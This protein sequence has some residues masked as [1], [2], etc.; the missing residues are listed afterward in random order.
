MLDEIHVFGSYARGALDPHD[1]D[2]A[3]E[4]TADE[5][6]SATLAWHLIHGSDPFAAVRHTL[7]GRRRG[8][9]FRFHELEE[10]H[11][12]GIE[13]TLLWRRGDDLATALAR[14]NAITPDPTAGRAPRDGMLPAFEG[15][16][17]WVPRPVREMLAA[18]NATGAVKVE[19]IMLPDAA[20]TGTM[21]IYT[22]TRRW[23][24][25][26]PLRRAANAAVAH[27]QQQGVELND[28]HLH[29]RDIIRQE[30]TPY[31]VGFQFRYCQHIHA[32]FTEWGGTQWLEVPHPTAKG[33]LDALRINLTDPAAL[34]AQDLPWL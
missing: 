30:I 10:L 33:P 23:G 18:W 9:Q 3:V 32:A 14:L 26:S 15:I 27:L 7:I 6:F 29:G 12:A 34:A 20:A 17:R 1:V 25:A 22:I 31:F 11:H 19:R 24:G 28:I 5:E 13:T 16:D 8:I 2:L 4:L 21:A